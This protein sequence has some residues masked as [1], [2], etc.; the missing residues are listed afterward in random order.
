VLTRPSGKKGSADMWVFGYGSLMWDGWEERERPVAGLRADRAV[1]I[2]HRRAFNKKSEENWGTAEA[3]APT[4]GL[5]PD[6]NANCIGT[7]FEFPDDQRTAIEDRLRGRE[8]K[9]FALPELPVRLPDG[10]EVRALTPVNDRS[11]R[12]YIGKISIAQRV[13]LAKTAKGKCGTCLDYVRNI[14]SKLQS[15]GI[16]DT[17][18]EEFFTLLES[19][20]LGTAKHT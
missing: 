13:N 11:K 1:L 2:K 14:H 5:E 7:A 4:L 3:P 9:S 15:L 16:V 19:Q 6:E 10:R 18:V 8:G 20:A 12:T 17:D